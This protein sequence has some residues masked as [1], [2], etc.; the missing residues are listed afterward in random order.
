M[1][2]GTKIVAIDDDEEDLKKVT[3]ALNSLGLA[4]VSVQYPDEQPEEGINFGGIRLFITDINL[5]G[6]DSPGDEA[7]TLAPAIS[8][9]ERIIAEDNGPYALISWSTTT[10]HN[11][12]VERIKANGKLRD[13]QPFFSMP[14][15]KAEFLEDTGKL[16]AAIEE[17]L[18]KNAPFGAILDWEKRV[19]KAGEKVLADLQS[20]SKQFPN[21]EYAEKMD[22]LLSK[23]SVDAFGKGHAS[24]HVFESVNEALMPILGDALNSEFF[25]RPPSDVWKTAVTKFNDAN[26][27]GNDV[28][29]KLNSSVVLEISSEIKPYRRGAILEVPADWLK[30]D[31]FARSFGEKQSVI[32]GQLLK[33]QKPKEPKWVLIQA[34]AACDFA[35]GRIG[36]M[37]YLLAA[38][39]PENFER[40]KKDGIDLS[41]PAS[42]WQSPVLHKCAGISDQQDFHFEILHGICCQLTSTRL[43]EVNFKVLGRLKDQ[44]VTSIGYE[45]H[46]HG[47]RPGF[48]SFQRAR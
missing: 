11:A 37:P 18:T 24:D 17:I 27:L 8:L 39:V 34:Q 29:C 7:R 46:S 12:L 30:D 28:V 35:Q 4:C 48:V 25:S 36:P 6:G 41:L 5:L 10:L 44:I 9:I 32:R 31:E 14:L 2:P 40:K 23:L 1:F 38:V 42:V 16:K 26:H 3:S 47:S 22:R 33:L 21:G 20:F 45:Y 15:A 19:S 43:S 13:R